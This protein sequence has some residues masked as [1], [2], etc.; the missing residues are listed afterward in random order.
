MISSSWKLI[1]SKD[2]SSLGIAQTGYRAVPQ[3]W[4]HSSLVD[5]SSSPVR[6][7]FTK[8]LQVQSNGASVGKAVE[9]PIKQGVIAQING[10]KVR[11]RF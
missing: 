10:Q 6:S 11:F 4:I 2:N 8:S 7:D 3:R 1:K 5:M 9:S